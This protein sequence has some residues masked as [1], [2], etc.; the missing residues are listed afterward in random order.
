MRIEREEHYGVCLDFKFRNVFILWISSEI[1]KVAVDD[2]YNIKGFKSEDDLTT[3]CKCLNL[4]LIRTDDFELYKIQQFL[5]NPYNGFDYNTFLNFWNLCTDISASINLDFLGDKKD[6]VRNNIYDKLF[7]GTGIWISDNP[8]PFF[9]KT[10][11][12]LLSEILSHGMNLMLKNL[13][14]KD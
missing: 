6:P 12:S 11:L 8:N 13:V 3:Y 5:I 10:E 14:V 7:N 4:K 2:N 1:D 9:E